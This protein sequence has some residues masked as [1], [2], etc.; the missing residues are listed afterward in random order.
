MTSNH[1][2]FAME[3]ATRARSDEHRLPYQNALVTLADEIE[4]LTREETTDLQIVRDAAERV[5]CDGAMTEGGSVRWRQ[6]LLTL[7]NHAL[8]G[9]CAP[10]LFDRYPMGT[11]FQKKADGRVLAM[12]PD[13]GVTYI[14]IP[15]NHL[16]TP[17]GEP[18]LTPPQELSGMREPVVTAPQGNAGES[19]ASSPVETSVTN[20]RALALEALALNVLSSEEHCANLRRFPNGCG[21]C[22]Y[23]QADALMIDRP[24][25]EPS[26]EPPTCT[27]TPSKFESH[28]RHGTFTSG[29]VDPNCPIHWRQTLIQNGSPV[30]RND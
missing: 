30:N 12:T 22:L 24:A 18:A 9:S 15:P 7:V 29:R 16:S 23:C 13:D 4:R 3:C 26:P 2:A 8:F 6:D 10:N 27:C 17:Q 28:E 21:E 11:L 19:P 14:A 5:R 1:L 20:E 25:V